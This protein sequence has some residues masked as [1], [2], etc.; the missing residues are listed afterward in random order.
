VKAAHF[1]ALLASIPRNQVPGCV[2]VA[3]TNGIARSISSEGDRKPPSHSFVN[4]I[5]I[6]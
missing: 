1:G 2:N 5:V 3:G 6:D 4:A